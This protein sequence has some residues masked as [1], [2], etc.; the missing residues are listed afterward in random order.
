MLS[1]LI[2]FNNYFLLSISAF[3][4]LCQ[5][6]SHDLILILHI[7][8]YNRTKGIH[9]SPIAKAASLHDLSQNG[10]IGR[11]ITSISRLGRAIYIPYQK[12]FQSQ[13]GHTF[14]YLRRENVPIKTVCSVLILLHIYIKIIFLYCLE[15]IFLHLVFFSLFK[16]LP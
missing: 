16:L 12:I 7:N 5:T 15:N 2:Y 3:R 11:N 10:F 6:N 4:K 9:F 14:K 1:Y 13:W 8:C